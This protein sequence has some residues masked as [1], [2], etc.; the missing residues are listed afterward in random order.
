MFRASKKKL[1]INEIKIIYVSPEETRLDIEYAK[2][3]ECVDIPILID[4]DY[5]VIDGNHRF[6][7][8][9]NNGYEEVDV[10]QLNISF[11][12]SKHLREAD[13]AMKAFANQIGN[14]NICKSFKRIWDKL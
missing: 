4:K 10:I 1:R 14:T 2:K 12:E 8:L 9:K 6:W 13:I 7:Y 11:T 5:K 3:G